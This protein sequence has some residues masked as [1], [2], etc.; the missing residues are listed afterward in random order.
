MAHWIPEAIAFNLDRNAEKPF[1]VFAQESSELQP[2]TTITHLEFS[3]AAHRIA[4]FIRPRRLGPDG[5][6]VACMALTDSIAYQAVTAGIILAGLVP[7]PMSPRNSPAAVVNLLRN[8]GCHRMIVTQATINPLIDG[9]QSLLLATDPTFSLKI[10]EVPAIRDI[11]PRLGSETKGDPFTAYPPATVRPQPQELC[12]Y[13]HSSGSTGFPKSIPLSYRT[14]QDWCLFPCI[15]EFRELSPLILSCMPLPPFHTLGI[16]TQ[17]LVP[18]YGLVPIAMYPPLVTSPGLLPMIASPDNILDHTQRTHSTGMVTIPAFLQIWSQSN[19]AL[20]IL[21]SQKIIPYSGGSLAPKLGDFLASL[22]IPIHAVYG[23]TELGAPTHIIPLEGDEKE[24]AWMRFDDRASLRWIPQG[25]KLMNANF[26]FTV[27]THQPSIENILDVKGYSTA[28]IWERHPTKSHL[29][30][31]VGRVDDV[32]IHSSG[33]KTVP[34]PMEDIILSNL[35]I[36]RVVMFGYEHDMPGIIIEPNQQYA[37]DVNNVTEVAELKNKVWP[38]IEEANKIA[39]A[40]SRIFR[41]M[42]IFTSREK[43]LPLTPKGTV[44]R[45]AA[46]QVYNKEISALYDALELGV[47][48]SQNVNPPT[49]W[50]EDDV[51][52]WILAEAQRLH[53]GKGFSPSVDLFEQGFDS[54]SAT[55]LRHRLLAAL[56]ASGSVDDERIIPQLA[57]NI[58][59]SN[60]TVDRLSAVISKVVATPNLRIDAQDQTLEIAQMIERYDFGLPLT[61]LANLGPLDIPAVVLLTGS[62]GNLGSQILVNLL[63]DDRVGRVYAFNRS[64][65]T[66]SMLKRHEA[67]FID[68]G[69]DLGLLSSDKLVFLS[70]DGSKPQ[71][72]LDKHVYEKLRNS[73]T[74]IIHNAWR[75]D[76]NLTLASFE[77]NVSATRNLLDLALTSPHALS[78][79]FLFTSSVASTQS[80]NTDIGSIPEE[81]VADAAIAIGGGYGESKY[82]SEQIITNSGLQASS[83]RIGQISGGMPNGAWSITEWMPSLVKTSLSLGALPLADNITISLIPMDAVAQAI[84]DV[85]FDENRPPTIMN[86][87]HPKP[88][89]WNTVISNIQD[90]ML[91]EMGQGPSLVPF[92]KWFELLEGRAPTLNEDTMKKFPAL[93]ILDF[94]R[95]LA[96]GEKISPR[97]ATLEPIKSDDASRWVA[98]WKDVGF[99]G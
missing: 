46:L 55:F 4:H 41:E 29:W 20:E 98:Y 23:A 92:H 89:E 54:L 15:R 59:Y 37:I 30:K 79:R 32:I 90:A 13:L 97:I 11:Y 40:F 10:E 28:D 36:L 67:R 12:I 31:I 87:V 19:A 50:Q 17:L 73:V 61:K 22:N 94:F 70:G 69:L 75:L 42:V 85:A 62:T 56:R 52:T 2:V 34:A 44:M 21:K 14:V 16:Y 74:L 18:L 6:V 76:F 82:V 71:L 45:K 68:R 35:L 86:L 91:R 26:W 1:F 57:P 38:I 64:S 8:T 84:I 3:R 39:P 7:F 33:E 43:P 78:I 77:P 72:A 47:K 96:H 63:I 65:T 99:L 48:E 27:D 9:I 88:V 80:W 53:N 25:M 66:A 24:W 58:L 93:K 51:R 81:L 95:G 83:F 49:S 5:E 60:P